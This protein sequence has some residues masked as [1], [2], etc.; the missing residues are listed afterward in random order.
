M[1]ILFSPH[2]LI[3]TFRDRLCPLPQGERG[4]LEPLST[5]KREF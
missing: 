4:N 1:I 2:S 3:K 5:I